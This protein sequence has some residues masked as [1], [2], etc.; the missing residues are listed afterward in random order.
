MH[1]RCNFADGM[2]CVGFAGSG[3]E[4]RRKGSAPLG[5]AWLFE[6]ASLKF[7]PLNL[8]YVYRI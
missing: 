6:D 7:I 2:G 8:R 5:E 3:H 4:G 1:H